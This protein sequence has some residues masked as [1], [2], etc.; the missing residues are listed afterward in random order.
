MVN[1]KMFGWRPA[2]AEDHQASIV[3]FIS[4][5]ETTDTERVALS[6]VYHGIHPESL[7]EEA[8]TESGDYYCEQPSYTAELKAKLH[9]AMFSLDKRGLV[10]CYHS[11]QY[12][13]GNKVREIEGWD[14][15]QKAKKEGWSYKGWGYDGG[16][17][18]RL[19][20]EG[21][22]YLEKLNP[23][24]GKCCD[25]CVQ[26]P[27]VCAYKTACAVHGGGCHGSHD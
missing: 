2:T 4:E 20:E 11:T 5:P 14:E 3:R 25:G 18:F 10:E 8:R 9:E 13:R 1:D 19:T 12:K 17:Y 16:W 26:L 21:K 22:Q 6:Y 24:M 23:Y 7:Y 15:Q 27:C